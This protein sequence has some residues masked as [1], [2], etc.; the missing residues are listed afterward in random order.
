[1]LVSRLENPRVVYAASSRDVA[2]YGFE[3]L[4]FYRELARPAAERMIVED[5]AGPEQRDQAVSGLR[6]WTEKLPFPVEPKY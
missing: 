3:D 5:G 6:Q 1:M 4:R 2:A